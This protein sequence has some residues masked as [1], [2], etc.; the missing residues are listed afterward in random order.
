M[1]IEKEI[2]TFQLKGYKLV[3]ERKSNNTG[4]TA[5]FKPLDSIEDAYELFYATY[6]YGLVKDVAV[7][8]TIERMKKNGH[9]EI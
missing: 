6:A 7:A 8:K 1:D 5:W 9:Q 4:W 2:F 3:I